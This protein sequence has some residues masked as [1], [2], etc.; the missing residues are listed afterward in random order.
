MSGDKVPG[1][2]QS[3]QR[4]PDTLAPSTPTEPVPESTPAGV[5]TGT[6]RTELLTRA[7]AFL[8]SPQIRLQDSDAKRAFLAEK[9]LSVVEIDQLIRELPPSVPPRTYPTPPPSN[10]PNLLIGVARIFTW[11]AGTS[12]VVLFIYY[13]YLLPRLTQSYQA[14]LALSKHHS[15]LIARLIE[16]ASALKAVQAESFK[17][18]PRPV[19]VYEDSRYVIFHTIDDVLSCT[20]SSTEESGQDTPDI[21]ILRCALE[22]LSRAKEDSSG[23]STE[24]LFQYLESKLPWLGAEDGAARQSELWNQLNTCPLFTS[25]M[26]KSGAS[27]L[28]P[29]HRSR[30]LWQYTPPPPPSTPTMLTSLANLQAALPRNS[31]VPVTD[32]KSSAPAAPTLSAAQ[33][34]LQV[35][36]DFTGYITTQTYSL[37]IS[38]TRGVTSRGNPVEDELRREI[39]AL[40]GLVLNRRSFLPPSTGVA[41]PMSEPPRVSDA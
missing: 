37:G 25:S 32:S 14:R 5:P 12:A 13:W 26:P 40:K 1:P 20:R 17:D 9:G 23:V 39:R 15:G 7:R 6:D 2:A 10:L 18:L 22:E 29:D 11:L 16:S 34:T 19:P 31:K 38:S 21:T 35:L 28:P 24:E 36:S 41:R 3:D 4:K 33:R 27:P 8:T 30:L